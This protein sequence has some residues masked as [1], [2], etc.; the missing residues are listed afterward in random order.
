MA[1][2]LGALQVF[3]VLI[4]GGKFMICV[5]EAEQ[6]GVEL[7]AT[8]VRQLLFEAGFC[9]IRESPL[10]DSSP[11]ASGKQVHPVSSH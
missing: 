6:S 5:R 9:D 10:R 11:A 8:L 4:P 7:P 2:S 3:H 1:L